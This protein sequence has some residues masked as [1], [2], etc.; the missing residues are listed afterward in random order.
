MKSTKFYKILRRV[1]ISI[2]Q[3]IDTFVVEVKYFFR[4]IL[5]KKQKYSKKSILVFVSQLCNGGAERVAANLSDEFVML[6]EL[7]LMKQNQDFLNII[8]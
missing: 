4:R 1:V 3:R 8:I 7:L 2:I 5:F 6:K